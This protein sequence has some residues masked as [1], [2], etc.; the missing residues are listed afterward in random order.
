MNKLF[1]CRNAREL[2]ITMYY[3]NNRAVVRQQLIGKI[4][5]SLDEEEDRHPANIVLGEMREKWAAVMEKYQCDNPTNELPCYLTTAAVGAVGLADDCWELQTL[6]RFRDT[7]LQR[8]AVGRRLA[9]RYYRFAPRL[10]A[11]ISRRADARTIWLKTWAFGIL[12]AAL[13][14]RVGLNGAATFIYKRMT[15]ALLKMARPF[16]IAADAAHAQSAR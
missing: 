15:L 1:R 11:A 7:V 8:T 16:P 4:S 9:S 13:C 2:T 14:A 10:V 6:R 3:R 5:T 12:P